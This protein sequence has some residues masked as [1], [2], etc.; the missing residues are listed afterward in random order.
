MST[1]P[2]VG[3]LNRQQ[4]Y[5]ARGR[6]LVL[7]RPFAS[8]VEAW[9][10]RRGDEA[11]LVGSRIWLDIFTIPAVVVSP[12]DAALDACVELLGLGDVTPP[13]RSGVEVGTVSRITFPRQLAPWLPRED[14]DVRWRMLEV[15]KP[16][17]LL[18]FRNVAVPTPDE[19]RAAVH[20]F[21]GR[22]VEEKEARLRRAARVI[23]R[24]TANQLEELLEGSG[25]S[26]R[27]VQRWLRVFRSQYR[28]QVVSGQLSVYAAEKLLTEERRRR[29]SA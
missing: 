10:K 5:Q 12:D 1:L 9:R 28:D 27:T 19:L 11:E 8:R 17:L 6:R 13:T 23:E 22:A 29:R 26:R 16:I 20:V 3:A 15:G 14:A 18:D 4:R 24:A 7:P 21:G 2:A 25:R